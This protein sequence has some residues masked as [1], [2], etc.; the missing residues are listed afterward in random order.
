MALQFDHVLSFAENLERFR[1]EAEK[2][3]SD[4]ARIL[5]DNLARLAREGD[6]ASTREVVREFNGAIL[7][8]LE[9]LPEGDSE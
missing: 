7:S 8:V 3:D 1:V 9:E 6:E 2:I 5:F 4:C